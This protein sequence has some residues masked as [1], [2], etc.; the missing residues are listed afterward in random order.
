MDNKHIGIIGSGTVG[1]HLGAGFLDSGYKV[2]IGTRSPN[3]LRDWVFERGSNAAAGS[4]KDA[5]AAG[6]VI[7]LA[8]KWQNGALKNAIDLAGKENFL[9]K[10]VIDVTN[11]LIFGPEGEPPVLDKNYPKSGSIQVK[12]WL[13]GS[14]IV[15]A[16]NT[17]TA[18]YMANPHLKEG[19]PDMFYCGDDAH[20]KKWVENLLKSWG[21][22]CHDLG[23]LEQAYLLEA[24]ALI[25][26]RYGFLNNHWTH[27][28]KLLQK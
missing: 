25:W 9:K 15:K 23:D 18:A 24:L 19:S 12:K 14:Y 28:F 4:F 21:W 20:A 13:P 7:V 22:T 6:D 5:A 3:K 27:A 1:L 8:S 26:V 16:F 2:T 11:P 17:V 10:I